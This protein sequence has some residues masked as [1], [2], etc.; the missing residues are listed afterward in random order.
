LALNFNAVLAITEPEFAFTLRLHAN[1]HPLGV[2]DW[3]A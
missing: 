2:L 3:L 1:G